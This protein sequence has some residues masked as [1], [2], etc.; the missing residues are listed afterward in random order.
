MKDNKKPS[1]CVVVSLAVFPCVLHH[2]PP[3]I[4]EAVILVGK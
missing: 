4:T 3:A 2:E 1:W